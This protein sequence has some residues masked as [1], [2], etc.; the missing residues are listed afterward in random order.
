MRRTML[1][2]LSEK[3]CNRL[4]GRRKGRR[5]PSRTAFLADAWADTTT[6]HGKL[7]LTVLG[8]LAEFERE[9]N[10]RPHRRWQEACEGPRREIR[11]PSGSLT[12]LCRPI[13]RA[14]TV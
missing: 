4:G 13:W 7:L 11:P 14:P 5:L 6:P 12:A 1:S 2:F 9:L 8:G 10:P 3:N